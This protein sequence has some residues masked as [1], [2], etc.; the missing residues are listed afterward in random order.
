MTTTDDST[1]F[2]I[3][4]RVWRLILFLPLPFSSLVSRALFCPVIRFLAEY[5]NSRCVKIVSRW[6]VHPHFRVWHSGLKVVVSRLCVHLNTHYSTLNT[7][8]SSLNTQHSTLNTQLSTLSP[9]PSTLNPQPSTL[10]PQ[11][12]TLPHEVIK[13]NIIKGF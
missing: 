10:N 7:Q 13:A 9:Q 2:L 12:S 4:A 5:Y 8:H 11:P 3:P 1:C 6:R